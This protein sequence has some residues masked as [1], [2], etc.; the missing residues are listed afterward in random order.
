MRQ[1]GIAQA[2]GPLPQIAT[3]HAPVVGGTERTGRQVKGLEP[4]SPLTVV[5]I[6]LGASL[7]LLPR[8]RIDQQH[9]KAATL[10]E[11]KPLDPTDPSR[12]QGHGRDPACRQ[13]VGPGF[14]VDC[15]RAKAAHWLGIVTGGNC[16]IMRF[17]PYVDTCRV[18][19]DGDPWGG[20]AGWERG[21]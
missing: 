12:F 5:P 15:I 21:S 10:S 9:F 20:S 7:E 19:G 17:S 4:L 13:P 16:H 11:L 3:Q 2:H 14:S 18:Q 8:W 1:A 6:A